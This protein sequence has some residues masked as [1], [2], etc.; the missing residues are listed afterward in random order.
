MKNQTL[1]FCLKRDSVCM[2]LGRGELGAWG[3][4][5]EGMKETFLQ[6]IWLPSLMNPDT[7]STAAIPGP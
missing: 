1:L 7:H 2:G 4:K 6:A 3:F 5:P